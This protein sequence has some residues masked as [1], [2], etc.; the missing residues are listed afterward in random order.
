MRRLAAPLV[1]L[2]LAGMPLVASAQ[3]DRATISIEPSTVELVGTAG[4]QVVRVTVQGGVPG[5]LVLS[6][7]DAVL[8]VGGAAIEA[9]LG[10]SPDSLGGLVEV[11]PPSF[12]Y[13]PAAE[14]V[15]F[16]SGVALVAQSADRPRFGFLVAELTT[17]DGAVAAAVRIPVVAV[18]GERV[19]AELPAGTFGVA[20]DD[21]DIAPEAFT[22]VDR[23]L[24]DL[25]GVIGHGPLTSIVT[26]RNVGS[27]VVEARV[28]W[29]YHRIGLSD[30]FSP[31]S[32]PTLSYGSASRFLIPG[33][34]ASAE[35]SSVLTLDAGPFD[36]MPVIGLVRVRAT[37]QWDLA[38][39]ASAPEPITVSRT[40]IVFPWSE[41]LA[42]LLAWAAWRRR[43][44]KIV[45]LRYSNEPVPIEPGAHRQVGRWRRIGQDAVAR[46]VG[47]ASGR[48]RRH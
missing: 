5:T 14:P 47:T 37:V 33:E 16:T 22:I 45:D 17:P 6:L 36:A 43:F 30:L 9:P 31:E 7:R 40:L 1:A 20:V 39:V 28:A 26:A 8:G 48:R 24:P 2:V 27:A 44:G 41:A 21:L 35:G 46:I 23:L 25:P 19:V 15:T 13:A 18:P 10:T 38:G 32:Q 34:V 11:V 29:T 42:A 3:T 4:P 12:D